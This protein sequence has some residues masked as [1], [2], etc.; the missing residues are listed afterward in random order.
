MGRGRISAT[1]DTCGVEIAGVRNERD[2]LGTL[3]RNLCW[4]WTPKPCARRLH[5]YGILLLQLHI[6]KAALQ[7]LSTHATARRQGRASE[8][9]QES[10]INFTSLP[11]EGHCERHGF[12]AFEKNMCGTFRPHLTMC[13]DVMG[14][15]GRDELARPVPHRMRKFMRPRLRLC[16]PR[17]SGPLPDVTRLLRTNSQSE[18]DVR[19]SLPAPCPWWAVAAC[20]AC[21]QEPLSHSGCLLQAFSV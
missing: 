2:D 4:N 10:E 5:L 7:I 14:F 16:L 12:G 1:S 18:C 17:P 3:T 19:S 13:L 6:Y 21:N 20:A 9:G 15:V 8:D 11:C